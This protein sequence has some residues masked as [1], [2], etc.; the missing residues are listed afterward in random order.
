MID[1][2]AD[3]LVGSLYS[4]RYGTGKA[5]KYS[6]SLC[7]I[8]TASHHKHLVWSPL[9]SWVASICGFVF[10]TGLEKVRNGKKVTKCDLISWY[11]CLHCNC[12]Q[13]HLEKRNHMHKFEKCA[14]LMY[15]LF[16]LPRHQ[17][18]NGM[19]YQG[20]QGLHQYTMPVI[21]FPCGFNQEE[22]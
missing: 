21:T 14:I 12:V 5:V 4:S 8:C 20:F 17:T 22:E 1:W 15:L 9:L 16:S 3:Y 2:I 6:C 19:M 13:L 11:K 18:P 7:C 10:P